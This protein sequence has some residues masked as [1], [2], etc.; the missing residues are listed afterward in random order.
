MKRWRCMNLFSLISNIEL[1]NRCSWEEKLFLTFDIDWAPEFVIKDTVELLYKNQAKATLFLT[2]KSEY[3]DEIKNNT[4]FEYG[5]HPNL[6][7]LLNGDFRYGKCFKEVINYY[8]DIEPN[9][10]S[11][12]FHSLSQSSMVLSYLSEIG[13][14]HESNINYPYLSGY[15]EPYLYS[16]NKLIRIP[17]FWEDDTHCL[18]SHDYTA[19]KKSKTKLK[20][21]DFH[22]IHVYLNTENLDR[23]QAAKPYLKDEKKL[24]EFINTK[25]YGTRDFLKELIK[26]EK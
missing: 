4:M 8:L 11:C 16:D 21:F 19:I 6:N 15:L 22:P 9:A 14:T 18:Y 23:Y 2:H 10:K 13:I 12:R 20:V 5:I 24:K 7:F 26:Y 25:T 17:Y 1:D 3:L